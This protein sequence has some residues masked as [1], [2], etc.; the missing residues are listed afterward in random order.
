MNRI[1]Q[2]HLPFFSAFYYIYLMKNALSILFICYSVIGFAQLN[3]KPKGVSLDLGYGATLHNIFNNVDGDHSNNSFANLIHLNLRYKDGILGYGF[4]MEH[5]T[6][7]TGTDSNVVFR[8]AVANLIQFNTTINLIERKKTCLY[9]G[10]GIGVG[11]LNYEQRD[12]SGTYGKVHMEGFSGSLFL[13]FNY[14]F[15]GKFGLFLQAG[16][17]NDSFKLTD[18]VVNGISRDEFN[19]IPTEDVVFSLRGMDFKAGV[20]FA[21]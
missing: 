18:F 16:Y 15:A 2:N 6:F 10:S 8:N 3:T 19:N 12:S 21:F 14:H 17:I 11:G 5:Y 20:R 9:I 7:A 13:G 1:Y 4:K